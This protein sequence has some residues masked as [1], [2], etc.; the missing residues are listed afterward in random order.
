[1]TAKWIPPNERSKFV[2]AYLGSSVGAALTFPL[3]G[4]IIDRFN[5]EAVFHISGAIGV[6]WFIAWW[7][8][9]YDTPAEH[10]RISEEERLYIENSIGK[11][12]T[13]KKV[14]KC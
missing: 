13:K 6:A 4:L 3:C 7:C 2:T 11:A 9:V 8:L 14:R 10:P 5:W 1:M 12:I